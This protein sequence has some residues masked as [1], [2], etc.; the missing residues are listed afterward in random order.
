[1]RRKSSTTACRTRRGRIQIG[2]AQSVTTAGQFVTNFFCP[3][4]G[5][6]L[7][8]NSIYVNVIEVT[9]YYTSSV[10]PSST[11]GFNYCPGGPNSVILAT[12][13]YQSP[14][15]VAAFVPAMGS[16][17]GG[18]FMHSTMSASAFVNEKFTPTATPGC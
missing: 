7:N 14:S 1:M 13:I 6:L 3:I 9:D 10:L 16:V 15:L 4:V 17:I 11:S 18:N 12:A 2:N 5:G 8:C